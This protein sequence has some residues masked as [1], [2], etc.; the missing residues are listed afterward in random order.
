MKKNKNINLGV[1]TL[2]E[3]E[4]LIQDLKKVLG[5]LNSK[6]S[7]SRDEKIEKY[8]NNKY[9]IKLLHKKKNGMKYY[10]CNY[11]H[12]QLLKLFEKRGG[13]RTPLDLGINKEKEQIERES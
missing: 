1:K 11:S 6:Y 7:L 10:I 3:A 9:G 13:Q 5:V 12:E 2:K 4:I 8:Y